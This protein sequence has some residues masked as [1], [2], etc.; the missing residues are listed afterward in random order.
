MPETPPD[1]GPPPIEPEPY[2][3]EAE[4]RR[5]ATVRDVGQEPRPE[6]TSS[7]RAWAMACH[8]GGLASFANICCLF[9][10]GV[11]VPLVVWLMQRDRDAFVDQHGREAVNFQINALLWSVILTPLSWCLVGLPLLIALNAA[12]IVLAILAAIE[13]AEGRSYRYPLTLRFVS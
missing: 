12:V 5:G 11:L 3:R 2:N 7:A 4:A 9:G 1:P 6:S 8:L 10:L 13:A